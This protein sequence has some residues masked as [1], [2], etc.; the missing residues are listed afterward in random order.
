MKL[1]TIKI[2][3]ITLLTKNIKTNLK[4]TTN[5]RISKIPLIYKRIPKINH[6]IKLKTN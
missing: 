6:G 3:W 5:Q 2:K 1:M 4:M